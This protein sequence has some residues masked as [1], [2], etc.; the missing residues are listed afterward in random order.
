M[1]TIREVARVFRSKL[2]LEGA[3]VR[4]KRA[5][6]FSEVPQ[7]DPFL[8][9]DDIHS[10]DPADYVA[11]FP[12]HPHRG[13]ET[14]TYVIEG[15]VEHGDSMGNKGAIRSGDVQWMTAGS[16]IVH[17]EMPQPKEGNFRGLQLWVNLPKSH[18]MMRPRYRGIEADQIPELRLPNGTLLKVIAGQYRGKEGPVKDI[19][20]SPEYFDVAIPEGGD[21]SHRVPH[22][23]TAFVYALAGEGSLGPSPGTPLVSETVIL[24]GPGEDIM[25]RAGG[26]GLRFLLISGEPLREPVSWRGPIVMNTEEE[27]DLA[28]HEYRTGNFIK[29]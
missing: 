3:G 15:I 8:L 21:F 10:G 29:G 14:V 23:H 5:I 22:D 25:A 18:K 26:R 13:I 11:G 17:Q 2:T 20:R 27:L 28:F 24:L 6:G 7:F 9:L 19:I 1:K 4:L 16:G 12:W